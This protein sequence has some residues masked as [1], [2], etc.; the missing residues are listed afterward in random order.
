MTKSETISAS[1]RAQPIHGHAGIR[2]P[3]GVARDREIHLTELATALPG[4][5]P[6]VSEAD[7]VRDRRT[8]T[9]RR[10]GRLIDPRRVKAGSRVDGLC[11]E[12]DEEKRRQQAET[13]QP[14]HRSS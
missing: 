5:V 1:I 4:R 11:G 14:C 7:C 10:P 12:C 9:K 2:R 6:G 13:Q 3:R 8:R